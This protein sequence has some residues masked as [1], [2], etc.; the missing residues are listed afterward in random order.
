MKQ[1]IKKLIK[2]IRIFITIILIILC[3]MSCTNITVYS[4]LNN[5][6]NLI[7]KECL[8]IWENY[9]NVLFDMKKEEIFTDLRV[10]K[11]KTL[12]KNY[13]GKCSYRIFYSEIYIKPQSEWS[14]KYTLLHEL[15]HFFKYKHST[16]I[17]SIMYYRREINSTNFIDLNKK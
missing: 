6:D 2:E 10:Y 14:K 5:N 15:G 13:I 9:E 3:V 16:N 7:L 11:V 8:L 1:I 4:E 17:N 12:E